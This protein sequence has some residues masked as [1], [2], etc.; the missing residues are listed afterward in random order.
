MT[1]VM[2]VSQHFGENCMHVNITKFMYV[3]MYIAYS[4]WS[5]QEASS[6]L[7]F[8]ISLKYAIRKVQGNQNILNGICQILVHVDIIYRT[9]CILHVP[10]TVRGAI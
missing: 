3:N 10:E 6:P 2:S 9:K 1:Q 5:E 4:E 8:N 7:Y